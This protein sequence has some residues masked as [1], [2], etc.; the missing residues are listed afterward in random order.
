MILDF[1]K[2]FM[3]IHMM[4]YLLRGLYV[5]PHTYVSNSWLKARLVW[6]AKRLNHSGWVGFGVSGYRQR[7]Y[8]VGWSYL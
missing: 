4:V 3:Y 2:V 7:R 8:F 1:L 5:M 6:L